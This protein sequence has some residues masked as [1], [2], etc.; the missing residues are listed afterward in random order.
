[1]TH[2]HKRIPRPLYALKHDLEDTAAKASDDGNHEL[3]Y[4]LMAAHAVLAQQELDVTN[5]LIREHKCEDCCE[6]EEGSK[7]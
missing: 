2:R 5:C 3:A 4:A 1:M 6:H 7:A